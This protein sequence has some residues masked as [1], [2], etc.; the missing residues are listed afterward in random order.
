MKRT[1]IAALLCVALPTGSALSAGFSGTCTTSAKEKWLSEEAVAAKLK[2]VGYDVKS[3]KTTRAGNCY[4][5]YATDKS[6]KKVE[7]FL[8][9]T[10]AKIIHTQ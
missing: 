9:P 10:D 8:D 5:A 7:L 1:F 6:G 4:E 3:I 2:D